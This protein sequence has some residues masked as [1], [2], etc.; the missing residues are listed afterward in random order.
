MP[1]EPTVEMVTGQSGGDDHE[2]IANLRRKEA[3]LALRL[4]LIN[5]KCRALSETAGALLPAYGGDAEVR[6]R[7]RHDCVICAAQKLAA[8][9]E[10]R[11]RSLAEAVRLHSFFINAQNLLDWLAE[12]KDRM[13]QPNG[14]R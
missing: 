2:G 5:T 12:A 14:L 10:T 3:G 7:V 13:S 11:A 6:L 9:A 8:T 1:A 4:T